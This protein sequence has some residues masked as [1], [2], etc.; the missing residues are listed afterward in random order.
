MNENET[1]YYVGIKFL[2]ND[3]S[4]YFSTSFNDLK[5]GDLVVVETAGGLEMGKV[6][7]PLTQ[8][9]EYKGSL[10]LKAI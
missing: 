6:S 10:E 1:L 8:I 2:G 3:K 9:N 5:E 7:T 4:Y